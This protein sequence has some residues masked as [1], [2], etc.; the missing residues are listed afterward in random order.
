[1]DEDLAA[2]QRA[3]YAVHSAILTGL[4][5][6]AS[7][8]ASYDGVPSFHDA[9]VEDVNLSMRGKS[10]IRIGNPY[11]TIY[12]RS[13]LLVTFEI[14]Q[15]I[16]ANL[17]SFGQNILFSLMLRHPVR[18]P[19]RQNYRTREILEGDVEFDFDATCGISGF[20]V[21]RNLSVRWTK[22]RRAGAR[23]T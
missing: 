8:I 2:A 16:D 21:G 15:V 20:V 3:E 7:L 13:R 23:R 6:A 12:D 18:R 10:S 22:D 11:P 19:E 14:G 4:P 9:T 17:D 1:M 5:G